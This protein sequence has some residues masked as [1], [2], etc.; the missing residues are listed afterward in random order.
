MA[1]SSPTPS[2]DSLRGVNS[3]SNS[4]GSFGEP[5]TDYL[6]DSPLTTGSGN[7]SSPPDSGICDE[8][9]QNRDKNSHLQHKSDAV[10]SLAAAIVQSAATVDSTQAP[11][12][13]GCKNKKFDAVAKCI[14]CVS[15]RNRLCK[16]GKLY[17]FLVS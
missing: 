1:S 13:T 10:T 11:R 17:S 16:L 14:D 8:F 6:S 2:L 4:T 15:I 12:C 9:L 7:G 3:H 5:A